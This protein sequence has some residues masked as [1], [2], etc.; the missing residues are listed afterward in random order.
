MRLTKSDLQNLPEQ[1]KKLNPALCG[2]R[3]SEPVKWEIRQGEPKT[4]MKLNKTERR[5]LE[6][7]RGRDYRHIGIQDITLRLGFDT[8]YTPDFSTVD[9]DGVFAFWEA[10]GFMR[11]DAR[12]KLYVAAKQ[13][14]F[15]VF[16]MVRWENGQWNETLIPR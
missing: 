5:F 3:A 8:R 10:K 4:E 13:F 2:V 14:P 16:F 15:F 9:Q 1:M 6:V 12:V 11:D 7:L